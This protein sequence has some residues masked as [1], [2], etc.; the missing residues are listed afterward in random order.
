[1]GMKAKVVAPPVPDLPKTSVA[2]V[3]DKQ[4]AAPIAP[5]KKLV[6]AVDKERPGDDK[7]SKQD[8]S[9]KDRAIE[10]VA[11]IKSVLESPFLAQLTMGQDETTALKTLETVFNKAV[12]V[13]YQK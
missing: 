8:W 10:R 11:I 9:N 4:A 12:A 5:A 2:P 7:M 3:A 1:M 6:Q 13:F